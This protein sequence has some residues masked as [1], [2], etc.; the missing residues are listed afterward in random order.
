MRR[1]SRTS[2]RAIS[3]KRVMKGTAKAVTSVKA[4][5]AE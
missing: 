4:P 5:E 2:V 1:L 3:K